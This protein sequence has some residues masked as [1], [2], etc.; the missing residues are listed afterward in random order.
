[1][2]MS[3]TNFQVATLNE[4]ET[5]L[6]KRILEDNGYPVGIALGSLFAAL[7]LTPE[8]CTI[9]SMPKPVASAI[10]SYTNQARQIKDK[11]TWFLIKNGEMAIQDI[12]FI[13][14]TYNA[15]GKRISR[16]DALTMLKRYFW[17]LLRQ[18]G[19]DIKTN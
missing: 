14:P 2:I 12:N 1:M 15:R 6:F 9:D 7:K 5:E 11:E 13:L 16:K 4:Q 17:Q 3:T 10:M 19:Y 18:Q 8:I